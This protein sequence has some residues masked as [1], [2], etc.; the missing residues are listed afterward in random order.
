MKRFM[1]NGNYF[2]RIGGVSKTA[3]RPNVATVSSGPL[4]NIRK[5]VGGKPRKPPKRRQTAMTSEYL[6]PDELRPIK[7][8]VVRFRCTPAEKTAIQ[9]MAIEHRTNV[10]D[11]VRDALLHNSQR[12]PSRDLLTE[13]LRQLKGIGGNIDQAV[14]AIHEAEKRHPD[15]LPVDAYKTAQRRFKSYKSQHDDFLDLVMKAMRKK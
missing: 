7:D 4:R 14:K 15:R 2:N 6:H 11:M 12:L 10:S 8:T 5:H 1:Q 3:S 9:D 13:I